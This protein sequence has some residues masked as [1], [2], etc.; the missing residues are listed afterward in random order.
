MNEEALKR[1]TVRLMSPDFVIH[2]EVLGI[3]IATNMPVRID[4]L[5]KAKPHLIGRGFSG[6]WFGVENKWIAGSN[7]Q[8]AKV[9]K[10]IWQSIT[11]A[12]SSFELSGQAI[13]PEFVLLNIPNKIDPRIEEIHA[14]QM[15]LA[16]YGR[17]GKLE[18]YRNDDWVIKFAQ[19]YCTAS[20]NAKRSL[21]PKTRVGNIC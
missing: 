7:G 5:M 15:Q 17:V 18:F 3:H 8:T 19:V 13:R 21:I 2:Q 11:Y 14:N 6:N 20:S 9:T 12:E 1:Q 10:A 4:F 16:L